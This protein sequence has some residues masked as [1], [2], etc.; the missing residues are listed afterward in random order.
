MPKLVRL[1]GDSKKS[2]TEINNTFR[3]PM[4]I[5]PYSRIALVGV[6][7]LMS[8]DL[9]NSLFEIE[10]NGDGE[11]S[12]GVEGTVDV[13]PATITPGIYD[14]HEFYKAMQIAANYT[15]TYDEPDLKGLDHTFELRDNTLTIES[16]ASP[17]VVGNADFGTWRILYGTAAP[18]AK[19][20]LDNDGTGG[21]ASLILDDVIARVHSESNWK[22]QKISGLQVLVNARH[23]E[24]SDT[25][26]GFNTVDNLYQKTIN[27]ATATIVDSTGATII[28]ANGDSVFIETFGGTVRYLITDST[29]VGR[30][31][32][33]GT[34]PLVP[35]Q[36]QYNNVISRYENNQILHWAVVLQ[37]GV[38]LSNCGY[39]CITP[40]GL[41]NAT[42]SAVLQFQDSAG[43]NNNKLATY[44]GFGGIFSPIEYTGRP[45]VLTAPE[46]MLGLANQGAVLITL[47]GVGKIASFD[48]SQLSKSS[49]N[50]VYV[51]NSA[52]LYG[53]YIQIDVASLIY[54][55]LQNSVELNVN[56]LRARF[57]SGAGIQTGERV[58]KFLGTP[59]LTFVIDEPK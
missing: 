41:G 43:A 56:Q 20:G 7:A 19:S 10:G 27:G 49:T 26:Y 6:S 31:T 52:G 57:L 1:L 59:S 18:V 9:G 36:Y 53:Q 30:G 44:T 37:Q 25:T 22:L 5:K 55:D 58:L 14:I 24:S 33:F 17:Y 29:G 32:G 51:M 13:I 50:T 48:G 34:T 46:P 23:T 38:I 21:T 11:F 54:L 39:S 15:G 3:E 4:I 16:A 47:D 2:D 45:A 35:G 8:D 40:T 12:I 28:P 42:V